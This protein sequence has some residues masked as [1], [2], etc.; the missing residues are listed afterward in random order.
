MDNS[1]L[2]EVQGLSVSFPDDNGRAMVVRD[3]DLAV[4]PGETVALVGESGSGK[5][6]TAL[7]VTR[8]L[9]HGPGRIISGRILYR[10]RAGTLR[11]L[12]REDKEAMRGLRGPEIAMVFQQPMSSL[13]PVMRIGDQIAEGI[14]EHQKLGWQAALAEAQ[15][16][17]ERVRIPDAGRQLRSYPFEISGGMRQRA[18]IAIALAS[19][20]RLLI[21]DEPTTAL[22][23]TVQAQVL[24]LLHELQRELGTGLLFITHDM[25]VVA[26]LADR[27][28]VMRGGE[29]LEA[30]SV[31]KVFATPSHPYT[32]SL[33]AAVPV[34]GSLN[35]TALPVPFA[36]PPEP[37]GPQD[38]VTA[39]PP[40][41][42]VID[43]VTRF[44][45]RDALGGVRARVH[46]VEQVSLDVRPGE[47]LALVG[48]SGCG[49]STLGRSIVR[50]E[51]P[52]SGRILFRGQD[53]LGAT[54]DGAADGSIRRGIQYVFQDPFSALDPRLTVGFSVAEP[55]HAHGLAK[56]AAVIDRVGELLNLVGLPREFSSRYP[57]E[58]SGG[59]CQRIGIAR[60]LASE[61]QLII[62]DEAVAALDVSIR[63]QIVN[64]L[65]GL[66]RR[67][68]LACL[69]ISHDMAVV[70]RI[71]HRIAV[72]YLGQI[73][74]VGPRQAVLSSPQHRYTRRLLSAVPVPDPARRRA[75]IEID[76]TEVPS[77]LR[78]PND[79]PNVAPLVQVG[80]EHFVARHRVG[81]LY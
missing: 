79:I 74:E 11:D 30:G 25:G 38:T 47:T 20:P 40:V 75:E 35:D 80:P 63:A 3:L 16:L 15:R 32:R 72:M 65:M 57:H 41:L 49:K 54:Q 9:D 29:Q 60:A 33:L 62:A 76:D 64:L 78:A 71:S 51:A 39:A 67:L 61:P 12:A 37:S 28:V 59:Q 6:V 8:L 22:D 69:F 58:L 44:D 17:L 53:V 23:V 48:E 1:G 66:Q 18:M 55:I 50:L 10:D 36:E 31:G 46:A 45:I 42:E 19:R 73:V 56:G 13:N 68:G 7:A 21:A 5:S 27:I 14:V 81:G 52:S 4:G 77:P 24:R 2:L 43:L 26:E 34:L 70:E